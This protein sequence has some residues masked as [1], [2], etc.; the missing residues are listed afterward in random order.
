MATLKKIG[1]HPD[2]SAPHEPPPLSPMEVKR[3]R[4]A[5]ALKAAE[6]LWKDRKDMPKDG[7]EYQEQLRSEWP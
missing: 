2:L 1:E 3:R 7:V 4:L 6:G 5:A